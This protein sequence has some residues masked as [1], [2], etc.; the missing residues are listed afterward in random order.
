[1]THHDCPFSRFGLPFGI[2]DICTPVSIPT[3]PE[4]TIHDILTMRHRNEN[5][6][7]HQFVDFYTNVRICLVVVASTK[8]LSDQHACLY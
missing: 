5:D 7:V 8:K 6:T 2:A 3:S 1:V 4:T